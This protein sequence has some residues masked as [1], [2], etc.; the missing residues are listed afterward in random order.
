MPSSSP[1][2]QP[3]F[4]LGQFGSEGDNRCIR[5]LFPVLPC[6]PLF[7]IHVLPKQLPTEDDEEDGRKQRRQQEEAGELAGR[8]RP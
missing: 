2:P 6:P 1:T 4:H 7:E 8:D 5:R 3:R